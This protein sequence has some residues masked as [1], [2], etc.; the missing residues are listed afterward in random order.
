MSET[1]VSFPT[2]AITVLD[3]ASVDQARWE[4]LRGLPGV[5][6]KVLW[7]SEDM[8]VGLVRLEPGAEEPGHAH[9]DA[10]HHVYVVHGNARIGGEVVHRGGFVFVPA[11]VSH[12][13][14]DVGS[15]GCTLFYTYVRRS[16]QTQTAP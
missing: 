12:A 7:R 10:N 1:I 15:E 8:I 2:D 9:H 6:H 11:G 3:A 4:P 13:T 5:T 14:T 16:S